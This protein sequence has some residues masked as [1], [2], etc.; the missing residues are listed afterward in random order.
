VI[1]FIKIH[2]SW[3]FIET[4]SGYLGI[5]PAGTEPGYI[6]CVLKECDVPVVLRKVPEEDCYNLIGTTFI[7]GL[8]DGEAAEIIKRGA[9]EPQ[10]FELR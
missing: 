10:W 4:T 3:R 5:S 8:M 1:N 2:L 6:I 7:V 9:I